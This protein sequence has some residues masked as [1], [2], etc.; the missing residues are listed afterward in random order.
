ML[1][2]IISDFLCDSF[3]IPECVLENVP[4]RI[5]DC[6]IPTDFVVLK[7]GQEHKN[8]LIRGRQFL[9]TDGVIIDVKRGCIGLNV[10]DL[11]MK[12]DMDK[13]VKRTM[14]DGQKF[15][16]DHCTEFVEEIF[17][18]MCSTDPLESALTEF[19]P[20]ACI[21]MTGLLSTSI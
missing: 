2:L 19:E 18:E 7:Y 11:V 10:G 15:F 8:P 13:L 5:S 1:I 20:E 16:V 6:L 9:A 4:I 17:Q 12:F 21:R 14:I 3:L